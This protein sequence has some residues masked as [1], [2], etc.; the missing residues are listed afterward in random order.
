[1]VFFECVS[2]EE[3]THVR[4][5]IEKEA[6]ILFTP[7]FAHRR[8]YEFGYEHNCVVTLDNLYPLQTGQKFL[9]SVKSCCAWTPVVV[10]VTTN[11]L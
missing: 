10:V 2:P 4:T 8:E 6:Q 9:Q 7:N 1:M 11:M 5:Y 3:V